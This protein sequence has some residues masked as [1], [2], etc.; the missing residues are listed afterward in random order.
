M[1]NKEFCEYGRNVLT[2]DEILQAGFVFTDTPAN[3]TLDNQPY[4]TVTYD[5]GIYPNRD[6]M[7]IPYDWKSNIIKKIKYLGI[8]HVHRVY[9]GEIFIN[10]DGNYFNLDITN[11]WNHIFVRGW[12]QH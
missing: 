2:T 8:T 6:N 4:I 10:P 11:R 7:D 1:N 9:F 5:L 3:I 12:I